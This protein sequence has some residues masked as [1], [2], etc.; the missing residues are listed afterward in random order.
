[1]Q[2]R[3]IVAAVLAEAHRHDL[4]GHLLPEVAEVEGVFPLVGALDERVAAGEPPDEARYLAALLLPTVG[5]RYPLAPAAN[6]DEAYEVLAP[7]VESLTQRYQISAHLRHLARD[8][9]LSCYRIARGRAY[10]TKGKFVR[11]PEFQEA[12]A[13]FR[14]WAALAGGLDDTVAYWEAYLSGQEVPSAGTGG[15]RRRRP[16]RRRG[17]RPAAP[18]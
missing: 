4:L 3:G 14:G 9:L 13:L 7:L 1:M 18:A 16:R 10:R 15:R 12:W 17:A 8:L 2:H 11:K 5:A 6:L